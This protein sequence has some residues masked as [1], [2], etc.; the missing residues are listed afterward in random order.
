[1]NS[2]AIG[3]F[4]SGVGGLTVLKEVKRQLPRENIVY[5]GDNARVPYGSKSKEKIKAISVE[6]SEFLS[7]FEVKLIVVA[8]NTASAVALDHLK[9]KFHIPIIGVIEAGAKAALKATR[10]KK[11]GV[12]GTKQTINSQT[13]MNLIKAI[14][15]EIEVF[16]KATPLFAQIVEEDMTDFESTKMLIEESLSYFKENKVD[17][18]IL[19]CTHYP[20]LKKQIKEFLGDVT[21]IDP[22]KETSL[23]IRRVLARK[24]NKNLSHNEYDK[25][26]VTDTPLSFLEISRRFMNSDTLVVEQISLEEQRK[27]SDVNS[28]KNK[29]I[30]KIRKLIEQEV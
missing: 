24:N 8:C 11:I 4:D 10:N 17:T 21:L 30:S 6:N 16:T 13:H 5:L 3:I 9:S 18:L 29:E 7:K 14:D 25:I 26:F 27:E 19:G 20:L 2:K 23:E 22:S 1:M 28:E 15:P 12:I